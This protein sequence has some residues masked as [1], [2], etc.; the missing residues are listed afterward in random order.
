MKRERE[1]EREKRMTWYGIG[2]IHVHV[3]MLIKGLGGALGVV[4]GT[5]CSTLVSS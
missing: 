2:D 4:R 1:R 3:S 5:V